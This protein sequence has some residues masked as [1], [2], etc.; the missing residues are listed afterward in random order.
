[1]LNNRRKKVGL[2]HFYD[3]KAFIEYSNEMQHVNKILKNII[4]KRST[5]Y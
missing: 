3:P 2:D 5:K 1:M 4:L